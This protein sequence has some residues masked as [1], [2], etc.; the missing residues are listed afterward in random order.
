M[1]AA[2]SKVF[3]YG[4]LLAGE[5][6][7]RLLARAQRI[8][9]ARTEEGFA[10]FDLGAFPGMVNVRSRS[11]AGAV[12]GE[13]YAVDDETLEALD[14]LEGH[15]SFYRRTERL[16]GNR[17]GKARLIVSRAAKWKRTA[18]LEDLPSVFVECVGGVCVPVDQLTSAE[19]CDR[20]L[21][22]MAVRSATQ[23]TRSI[24]RKRNCPR[25]RRPL[26][27]ALASSARPARAR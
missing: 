10:L 26:T 18:R 3:V 17:S 8:G 20:T 11:G 7:S 4:T 5:P 23:V 24:P 12:V 16:A 19:A 2:R 9:D 25:P 6:N 27:R 13:L 1:S 15:P 14:R 22:V 21:C